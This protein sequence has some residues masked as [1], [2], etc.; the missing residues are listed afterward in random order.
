MNVLIVEG[1]TALAQ[2]WKRHLE[3]KSASVEVT[4]DSA[5][6]L[7]ALSCGSWDVIILNVELEQ[8]TA[9]AISDMAQFRQPDA[10]VMFITSSNF[11]SDGSIFTLC[12]NACCYL[13][14]HTA[15]DDLANVAQHY[16]GMD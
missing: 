5:K 15:P 11:F 6:A 12:P 13:P 2:L 7:E 14:S 4:Q 16:A 3:R 10:R 8:G 9:F 1:N